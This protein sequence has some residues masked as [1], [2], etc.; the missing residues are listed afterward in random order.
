MRIPEATHTLGTS[1]RTRA[2]SIATALALGRTADGAIAAERFRRA[3]GA[4]PGALGRLVPEYLPAVPIDP[5]SGREIRYL[6]AAD[7][8]VVYS[9]GLNEKDDGGEEVEYPVLRNGPF[10]NR[11]APPDFGVSISVVSRN[12]R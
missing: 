12:R 5:F 7:R 3:T 9:V 10:Q 4:L 11:R 1:Y 2:R 8:V 6:N